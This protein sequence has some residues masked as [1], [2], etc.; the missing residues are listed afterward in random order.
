MSQELTWVEPKS[1]EEIVTDLIENHHK[2]KFYCLFSGGK[3]SVSITHYMKKNY[4]KR[5]AGVI[6]TNTGI[7]TQATRKWVI[8]YCKKQNWK[9]HMT[10]AKKSYTKIVLDDGFPTMGGHR[11]IMGYLKFQSWYEFMRDFDL[12]DS[13]SLISGVRKK[14]SK[15]R[16]K[17]KFYSRLPIDINATILQKTFD[18]KFLEVN[19]DYCGESCESE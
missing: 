7:A 15:M 16:D 1:P 13:G 14:E 3:D 5:F 19:D 12:I 2:D 17:T 6:F 8:D 18:D 11:I 10:W 9:L 4:H